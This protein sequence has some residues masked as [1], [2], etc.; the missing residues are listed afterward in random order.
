[1]ILNTEIAINATPKK[2]WEILTNFNTYPSWNPLVKSLT[3]DVAVGNI[4][5]VQLDTMTFK[6]KVLVYDKDKEFEW[7][8]HLIFKGLFDGQH[9]FFLQDNGD[10]TTQFIHSE[11]FKGLLVPLMKKKLN[12]EVRAGFERMNEALKDVAERK[13]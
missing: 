5:K 6:P 9:R 8:G 11:N 10:G 1:M 3:G 2:I 12:T 7:M 4:I 13:R